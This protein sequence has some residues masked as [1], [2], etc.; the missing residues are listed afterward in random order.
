MSNIV[1]AKEEPMITIALSEYRYLVRES[2]F[3]CALLN[4]GVDS[5]EGY[6]DAQEDMDEENED[7]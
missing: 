3:L 2:N 5:W 6:G 1:E 4:A 7:E